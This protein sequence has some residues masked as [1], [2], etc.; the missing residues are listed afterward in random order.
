MASGVSAEPDP[1]TAAAQACERVIASRD[2]ATGAPDLLFCFVSSH[3]AWALRAIAAHAERLLNP[4][5]LVGS[6]CESVLGECHELEGVPGVSILAMWLPGVRISPFLID[7]LIVDEHAEHPDLQAHAREVMDARPDLRATIVL[8]DPY[9]VPISRLL[10]AMNRARSNHAPI[11]GAMAS[12]PRSPDGGGNVMIL[13]DR[14]M[15]RGGIGVSLSGP[16]RVD[17]VVS[18]GCRPIGPNLIITKARGNLVLELGSRPALE[19][20]QE[21]LAQMSDEE[22]AA[23]RRGLLLGRVADEYKQRFGVGDYLIRAMVGADQER[24]AIAVG[25]VIKVGQTVRLHVRDAETATS[26]LSML[27]D[28]QKLYGRP[29]GAMVFTCTHRGRRLFN[30]QAHDVNAIQRAFSPTR[31]GPE[32]AKG[33]TAIATDRGDIPIAGFFAAGEIGPVGRDAYL[34]G[35]TASIALFRDP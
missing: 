7:D 33:G 26:D 29:A 25:E 34:H 23:L 28:G 35:H 6:T 2:R 16:L 30:N 21:L 27:L 20:V 13:D 5:R 11:I 4:A 9:S 1:L 12:A 32:L 3:H 18:Q 15:D 14:T 10:P 31:N 19:V 22:R 17:A 8:L 24:G